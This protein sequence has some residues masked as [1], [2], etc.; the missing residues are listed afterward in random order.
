MWG[1][2]SW[3]NGLRTWW[4]HCYGSSPCCGTGLTPGWEVPHAAREAKKIDLAHPVE[5]MGG[6]YAGDSQVFFIKIWLLPGPSSRSHSLTPAIEMHSRA[7]GTTAFPGPLCNDSCPNPGQAGAEEKPDWSPSKGPQ[8][9][10][11]GPAW[12]SILPPSQRWPAPHINTRFPA[13]L[14]RNPKTPS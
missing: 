3:L 13:T 8:A 10:G 9:T 5:P 14:P 7:H 4:C 11:P 1:V 12:G 2:P 6:R